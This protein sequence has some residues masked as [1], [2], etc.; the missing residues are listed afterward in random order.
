MLESQLPR[1]LPLS[2]G[3]VHSAADRFSAAYRRRLRDIGFSHGCC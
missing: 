1:E 3:E 2:R